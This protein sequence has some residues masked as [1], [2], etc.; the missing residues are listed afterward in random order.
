MD[1]YEYR[2]KLEQIEKLAG[3]KDYVTAAEIAD[4]IDWRKVKNVNTL[5]MISDIYEATDRLEDCYEI[6]NM[7]Y[8]RS[9]TGRRA[10]YRLTEVATKMHEFEEA[11][12][13][14]KEYV[15]I[16]PH[17]LGRYIL[18][19]QIYRERGSSVEDQIEVL[20]EYKSHEYN[21]KWAYELA[22][23]YE[24]AGQIQKC[25]E[26]C[27]ELILWFG[28]GE[29]V[30]KA[31]ELKRKYQEL[32]AAQQE[33]YDQRFV[34]TEPEAEETE[35][36]AEEIEA[37]PEPAEEVSEETVID[38]TPQ[39]SVINTN[40]FSTMNLQ[41]ELAKGVQD[42]FD[43]EP[44]EGNEEAAETE[45]FLKTGELE[46]L[47]KAAR[48]EKSS[49]PTEPETVSED[50]ENKTEEPVKAS[51]EELPEAEET[52][53]KIV[54]SVEFTDQEAEET[55][56][57]VSEPEDV[58]AE[59][60]DSE[61]EKE[62]EER[63]NLKPET[64][65]HPVDLFDSDM[66][67]EDFLNLPIT[68]QMTVGK[69]IAAWE[70]RKHWA[71]PAE[72]VSEEV[73]EEPEKQTVSVETGEITSLLKDFIPSTP[74]ETEEA[75]EEIEVPEETAE[76]ETF[77]EP[78][79]PVAE[80]VEEAPMG[81]IEDDLPQDIE[82]AEESEEPFFEH[83][84]KVLEEAVL[85]DSGMMQE[86]ESKEP[87]ETA[88]EPET[89]DE[90]EAVEQEPEEEV[91]QNTASM[92]YAIERALAQ[93]ISSS[94][95]SGKHLTEEQEKIFAYFTLVDGM[96]KQLLK[97]LEEEK[98]YAGKTDSKEG[99]LIITGHPGNG[100]TTLAIDI[101]K[102]FQKQRH[103]KGSKIAKVTGDGL[104]KKEP[105][106]VVKKLGGGALIIERAGS[107]NQETVEK[108]SDVMEGMTEGMLVILE[109]DKEEI[110]RLLKKNAGFAQKFNRTVNIPIF[111][112]NELVSF[113]KSYAEE[114]EYYF[115]EMAVLALYDCIGVRQT[116]EHVVNV[117]EV[118]EIIDEA[119]AHA[120]KKRKKL[121]AKLSKKRIDEY[122]NK[123]LLEE[124][125]EF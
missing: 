49:E 62:I 74:K 3:R 93:E 124:D 105:A 108:L 85:P 20:K 67:D 44:E 123:L 82:E 111:S 88:A 64:D 71:K 100:K 109:D 17:D 1:K 47:E 119:I 68:G 110:G 103:V 18:K 6:L 9:Y 58:L 54:I 52:S 32:T 28:S 38:D 72:P 36:A 107:L 77:V 80:V 13:L 37:V 78:E 89:T 19:Y 112:N 114:N 15:K 79:E 104:N 125:F 42:V 91:S 73:S 4:G 48:A 34:Q 46:E 33:K 65:G 86:E 96:K 16:A 120:E 7:V 118:K 66:S 10:V 35:S 11:I 83:L 29:Y 115:D 99:N 30:I 95:A 84:E 97:L 8:D 90:T 121:F 21:E 14:Y 102:V 70:A 81:T 22:C 25:I 57:P 43:Q 122:G 55:P 101:V 56:E 94:E 24:E 98:N 50:T 87:E 53:E 117:A 113:G 63:Q 106:E 26:E 69:V 61:A 51:A 5:F 45:E 27:D 41:A 39:I 23:L 75:E 116:S 60:E 31:L 92:L 2:I 76:A 40:K 12:D 59:P